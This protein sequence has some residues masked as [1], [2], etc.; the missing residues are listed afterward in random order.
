MYNLFVKD[1]EIFTKKINPDFLDIF[2][3]ITKTIESVDE[4]LDCEIKWGKLT[5]GLSGDYHHWICGIAQTKK[6]LNLIFHFGG[7]LEDKN[8]KFIVGESFFFRKLEYVS[9]NDIDIETIK[10]FVKQAINKVDYFKKNWK[11]LSKKSK[12]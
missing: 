1:K 6:S 2:N 5:Y 10:D 7:L 4:K 9:I 8:K 12:K 3:K 11:I